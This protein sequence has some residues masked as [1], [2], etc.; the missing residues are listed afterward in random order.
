M[1]VRCLSLLFT[2]PGQAAR[3]ECVRLC[4]GVCV[5]VIILHTVSFFLACDSFMLVMFCAKKLNFFAAAAA[6][7]AVFWS[8]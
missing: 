1:P 2:L 7:A 4:L 3:P 8:L 6:A 5:F